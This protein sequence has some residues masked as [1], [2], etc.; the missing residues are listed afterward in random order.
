V[1]IAWLHDARCV[2]SSRDALFSA[3]KRLFSAGS[4]RRSMLVLRC[5]THH[6]QRCDARVECVS[7]ALK[8]R[9]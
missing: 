2:M 6:D 4:T 9:A 3:G 5:I 7:S 1:R 8:Q